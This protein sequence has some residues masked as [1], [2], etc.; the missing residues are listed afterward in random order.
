VIKDILE[1]EV[2]EKY[3][4]NDSLL[5]KLKYLKGAKKEQRVKD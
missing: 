3:Y 1:D 5:E 4:L 2:D